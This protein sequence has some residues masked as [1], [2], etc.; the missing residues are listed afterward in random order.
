ME[1]RT[2]MGESSERSTPGAFR[3]LLDEPRTDA[4]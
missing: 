3:S 2:R 1:P 4:T